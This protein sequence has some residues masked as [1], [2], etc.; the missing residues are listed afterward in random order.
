MTATL[1]ALTLRVMDWKAAREL[2]RTRRR[3]IVARLRWWWARRHSRT[4][5]AP[6][7]HSLGEEISLSR[8][9]NVSVLA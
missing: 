4:V 2:S 9:L 8:R 7:S 1:S 3:L 6:Q 5:P